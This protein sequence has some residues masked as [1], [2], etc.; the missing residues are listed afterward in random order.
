MNLKA[1]DLL[2][3]A[4]VEDRNRPIGPMRTLVSVSFRSGYR[5]QARVP[6]QTHV[7][8]SSERDDNDRLKPKVRAFDTA[9]GFA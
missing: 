1:I 4:Y 7:S 8:V 3:A 9:V 5:P 2:A 6:A